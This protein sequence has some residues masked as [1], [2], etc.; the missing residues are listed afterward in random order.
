MFWFLCRKLSCFQRYCMGKSFLLVFSGWRRFLLDFIDFTKSNVSAC[1]LLSYAVF[2]A[3]TPKTTQYYSK[4]TK[5][6]FLCYKAIITPK[7]TQYYS[8]QT[9]TCFLCWVLR[10]LATK[11]QKHFFLWYKTQSSAIFLPTCKRWFYLIYGS[12]II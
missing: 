6:C 8:R 11:K 5:T 4:Q 12:K 2:G 9:K 3:I 7:T 1:L 10:V